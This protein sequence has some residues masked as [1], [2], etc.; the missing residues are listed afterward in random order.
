MGAAGHAFVEANKGA[1]T[2]L[3]GLVIP[4]IEQ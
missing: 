4:L 3:L 1:L 2:K